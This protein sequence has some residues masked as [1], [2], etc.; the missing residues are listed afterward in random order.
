MDLIDR[1]KKWRLTH[2]NESDSESESDSD[3]QNNG[4]DSDWNLTIKGSPYIEQLND[5]DLILDNSRIEIVVNQQNGSSELTSSMAVSSGP[6][7]RSPV[8][9]VAPKDLHR[10]PVKDQTRRSSS[11]QKE[12]PSSRPL[13]HSGVVAKSDLNIVRFG[14]KP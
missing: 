4:D 1:Y 12:S 2:S 14:E 6:Q 5:N 9:E 11:P 10:S 8:K 7:P 13:A 3:Q